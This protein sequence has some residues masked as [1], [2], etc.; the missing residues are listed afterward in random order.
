[1]KLKP[2]IMVNGIRGLSGARLRKLGE[3]NQWWHD[4]EMSLFDQESAVSVTNEDA[5]QACRHWR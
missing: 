1:M 2:Q 4:I 5:A 3:H